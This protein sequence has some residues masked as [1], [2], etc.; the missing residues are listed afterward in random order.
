MAKTTNTEH[1]WQRGYYKSMG[2]FID[3]II[4][5][6][7][8]RPNSLYSFGVSFKLFDGKYNKLEEIYFGEYIK[9]LSFLLDR[10]QKNNDIF[11][12]YLKFQ[13][14]LCWDICKSSKITLI[15]R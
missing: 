7:E 12:G 1:S 15:V 6:M 8:N 4:K 13:L 10:I 11:N 2:V 5:F 9:Y 3:N 14:P